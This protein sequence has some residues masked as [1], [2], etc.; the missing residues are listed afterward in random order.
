MDL[1][2]GAELLSG[3]SRAEALRDGVL[4]DV[5]EAARAAGLALPA[6]MTAAA[7]AELGAGDGAQLARVMGV[8]CLAAGLARDTDRVRFSVR[9]ARGAWVRAWALVGPG[10]DRQAVLTVMLEGED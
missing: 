8:V 10:D 3:Y 4:V 2:E 7:H 5:T 1:W 6:A 9:D